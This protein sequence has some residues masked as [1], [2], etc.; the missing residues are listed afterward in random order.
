MWKTHSA[1]LLKQ[2]LSTVFTPSTCELCGNHSGDYEKYYCIPIRTEFNALPLG[3]IQ[4]HD[5]YATGCWWVTHFDVFTH[6]ILFTHLSVA[7]AH[8]RFLEPHNSNKVTT[9]SDT[10]SVF[11]HNWLGTW[12]HGFQQSVT[13]YI[14]CELYADTYAWHVWWL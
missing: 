2:Q 6:N 13:K 5:Y 10:L 14:C 9:D 8:T 7:L 4:R 11:F 12:N 3:H 1:P